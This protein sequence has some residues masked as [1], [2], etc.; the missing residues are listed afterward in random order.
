[1]PGFT[2]QVIRTLYRIL[3]AAPVIG[4]ER[5]ATGAASNHNAAIHHSV[6]L[7]PATSAEH[8]N[9]GHRENYCQLE[10]VL[11]AFAIDSF[12]L[13]CDRQLKT[14]TPDS[15]RCLDK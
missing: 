8:G 4:I 3:G 12:F 1:V 9:R 14:K 13:T 15:G 7:T 2:A 11:D 5:I 6:A 10:A